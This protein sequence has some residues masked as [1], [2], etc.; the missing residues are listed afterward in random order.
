LRA[1]CCLTVVAVSVVAE[2]ARAPRDKRRKGGHAA[3]ALP[4]G[5]WTGCMGGGG[6]VCCAKENGA[7]P[8]ASVPLCLSGYRHLVCVVMLALGRRLNVEPELLVAWRVFS[9]RGFNFFLPSL[10]NGEWV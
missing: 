7:E 1:A 5:V 9:F 2:W 8:E 10:K 3:R 4:L 6:G